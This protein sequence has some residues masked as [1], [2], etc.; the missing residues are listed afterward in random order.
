MEKN[1]THLVYV[2]AQGV[3]K[4]TAYNAQTLE[5]YGDNVIYQGDYDD[6]LFVAESFNS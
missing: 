4:V 3:A 1:S 6:C 5:K 2:N